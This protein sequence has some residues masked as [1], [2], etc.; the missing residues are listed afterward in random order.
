MHRL[1]GIVMT[2]TRPTP[3]T[4]MNSNYKAARTYW[5]YS[6]LLNQATTKAEPSFHWISGARGI[7]NNKS[8]S[9]KSNRYGNSSSSTICWFSSSL[10]G[11]EKQPSSSSSTTI[12]LSKLLSQYASNLAVS[13]RQAEQ[14]IKEGHVTIAGEIIRKPHLLVDLESLKKA[15]N[16]AT[17]QVQGKPIVL[18]TDDDANIKKQIPKVWAVHKLKGEIV[19]ESDPHNRPSMMQRLVRGGVG[20]TSKKQRHHLKPIGRLDIPTEGLILVTSDGEYAREME[21]PKNQIHRV[22]RVRVH[23]H[24]TSY[25]LDRIRKGGIRYNN[26]RYTDEEDDDSYSYKNFDMVYGPMKVEIE[27]RKRPTSSRRSNNY[28]NTS[29]NTWLRVTSVEGK[30]RQIRNV[31][32]AIGG[33]CL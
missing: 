18:D 9:S 5:T 31:F 4:I 12:R 14:M 33:M 28:R 10:S 19:T 20:R 30:N 27:R 16:S 15:N 29:T 13:R 22:Y 25:K 32:Q 1:A 6:S 21:L 8:I 11:D 7:Y 24:L 17:I 23:G 26:N 2:K 3:S